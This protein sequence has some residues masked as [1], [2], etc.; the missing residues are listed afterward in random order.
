MEISDITIRKFCEC[1]SAEYNHINTETIHESYYIENNIDISGIRKML[2][3]N[4][5]EEYTFLL[6]SYIFTYHFNPLAVENT[7][8]HE[9]HIE[10]LSNKKNHEKELTKLLI[11]LLSHNFGNLA[12]ISF[13]RARNS[14]TI[15][16]SDIIDS[17]IK[18]TIDEFKRNKYHILK[19]T[20]QE[21]KTEMLTDEVW[22]NQVYIYKN[23]GTD[24]QP[25]L[26]E[27][28]YTMSIERYANTHFKTI[29]IDLESLIQKYELLKKPTKKGA[30][31]KKSGIA[32]L[33]NKLLFLKRI[34]N[35]LIDENIE[36]ISEIPLT[37]QEC[38]FI[39]DCLVCFNFIEDK[40]LNY[41][42]TLP[43]NFIKSILREFKP[44]WFELSI[45][46]ETNLRIYS[47]R[48][49]LLS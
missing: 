16:N 35:F 47:L 38:R 1:F 30:K 21:A 2:I 48:G 37:N 27:C 36:N 45:L 11:F 33:A 4:D 44:D 24:E 17:I 39:H 13:K 34:D 23:I 40:N 19:L 22:K 9:K 43:Q 25:E 18:N 42:K 14:I 6:L 28:D 31:T 3:K 12:S 41:S 32:F 20:Y 46:K 5:L 7:N 15:S 49:E 26:V 10:N 29:D 8:Q